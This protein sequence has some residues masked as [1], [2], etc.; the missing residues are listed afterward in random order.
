MNKFTICTKKD[1]ISI[2]RY[3]Q[4]SVSFS[5]IEYKNILNSKK[6]KITENWLYE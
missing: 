5:T 4:N 6:F 2:T 3:F 1:S